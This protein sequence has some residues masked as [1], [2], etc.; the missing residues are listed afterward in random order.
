MFLF[1]FLI[2]SIPTEISAKYEFMTQVQTGPL[3]TQDHS[4]SIHRHWTSSI[5]YI[6]TGPH[7]L[8]CAFPTAPA[9][10]PVSQ[11]KLAPASSPTPLVGKKS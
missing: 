8:R 5:I 10:T 1:I 9:C 6:D 3:P 11:E 7:R 4:A 2:R